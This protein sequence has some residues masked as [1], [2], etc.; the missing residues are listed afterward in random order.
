MKN[1]G[2]TL[3]ELL[4]VIVI[5]AIIAV[6]A[7]PIILN[8]IDDAK[9]ESD[10]RSVEL[11]ASAVRNGIAKEQLKGNV[12][13]AGKY[14]SSNGGR[15]LTLETDPKVVLTVDYEG[16]VE[17]ET[18][19][20]RGD[21]TVSLAGCTVNGGTEKYSYG[22][23]QE[24]EEENSSG[25]TSKTYANGEEVYFNVTTGEACTANDYTET[26]SNTEV[27][28]GCM[29]FYAFNDSAT[30]EKVNLLLDHNI[31]DSTDWNS[32]GNVTGGPITLLSKLATNT[33]N[34][35]GT[36]TPTNYSV[37]QSSAPSKANYTIDYT[38]YKARLITGE[39]IAQIMGINYDPNGFNLFQP[40]SDTCY[41]YWDNSTYK[42]VTDASGCKYG[43]LYDRTSFNC[44]DNGCLNNATHENTEF[45][46]YGYWTATS[47]EQLYNGSFEAHVVMDSGY[48]SSLDVDSINEDGI[49][50][51][52]NNID[53]YAYGVRP[54]IE[55]LKSK[56]S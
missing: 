13:P 45:D 29:K 27:K 3:I 30:N 31:V 48:Y 15:T 6:I 9:K 10:E 11:Y 5:L 56:L 33:E 43:W 42:E 16:D 44:I 39:E 34:W 32:N 51:E 8:I 28:T 1:K 52:P 20:V 7:V 41:S 46:T 21:G 23:N 53:K 26:Q 55:V 19:E 17:C 24:N 47:A 54:V 37:N 4:A 14:L 38:G 35:Q 18:T 49:R 40:S 36:E 50:L 22:K 12:L 2:F 25:S